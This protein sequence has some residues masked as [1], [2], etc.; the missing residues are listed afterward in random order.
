MSSFI[1]TLGLAKSKSEDVT[2]DAGNLQGFCVPSA[3]RGIVSAII[4]KQTVG[5]L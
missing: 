3:C 5:Q 4:D 1:L 2:K